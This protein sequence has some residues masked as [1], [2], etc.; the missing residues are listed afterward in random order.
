MNR[1]S[2][3]HENHPTPPLHRSARSLRG[4]LRPRRRSPDGRDLR[5]IHHQKSR[6]SVSALAPD[7][8]RRRLRQKVARDP[9][10]PRLRRTRHRSVEGRG[11]RPAQAHPRPRPSH[12]RPHARL[13]HKS[14]AA[15]G[16]RNSRGPR[17]PRTIRRISQ[18]QLHRRLPAMP[19]RHVV[20][21]RRRAR[22]PRRHRRPLPHRSHPPLSHR[23]QHGRLR[24]LERRD[25]IPRTFRRHRPHLRR[26]EHRRSPS[27][28]PRQE[29]R[30]HEPRRLGLPRG[31]GP[32]RAS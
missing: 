23:P 22:P 17:P 31:E 8:L 2:P 21:R 28:R 4:A 26:R 6:L 24:H 5:E 18:S 19:R 15:S 3:S 13:R 14:S 29:S 32:D 10:S 7:R 30:P 12:R 1:R 27:H 25:E 16:T 20:G 11:P 9:L